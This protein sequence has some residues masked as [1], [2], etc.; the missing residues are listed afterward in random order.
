MPKMRICVS[1]TWTSN[2]SRP[3][4]NLQVLAFLVDI[5]I[6][7]LQIVY[8][9]FKKKDTTF[10]KCGGKRVKLIGTEPNSDNKHC[11]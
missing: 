7:R 10:S 8:W 5:L 9:R 3:I 6:K 4:G 11:N 1:H 2:G